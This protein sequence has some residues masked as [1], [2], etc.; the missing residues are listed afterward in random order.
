MQ[1]AKNNDEGNVENSISVFDHGLRWPKIAQKTQ[2][3]N[4]FH[5][6]D[7]FHLLSVM[8][9]IHLLISFSVLVWF[10]PIMDYLLVCKSLNFGRMILDL[11]RQTI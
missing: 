2:N 5:C 9:I 1:V 4:T 11:V 8:P 10:W 7:D 3:F 6:F